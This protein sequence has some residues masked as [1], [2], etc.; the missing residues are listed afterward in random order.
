MKKKKD[1]I[2]HL[3]ILPA[4]LNELDRSETKHPAW[5]VDMIHAAAIV[6]EESGELTRAALKWAYE[7][8]D[9]LE[10]QKE[11]IQVAVT[12][13][14]FLQGFLAIHYDPMP[15]QKKIKQ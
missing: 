5:P 2:L 10:A 4:I 15:S 13:I 14:R 8:E 6:A 1:V 7:G 9:I 12:A 3:E 11:A